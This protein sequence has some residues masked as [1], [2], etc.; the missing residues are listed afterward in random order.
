[1]ECVTGI[2]IAWFFFFLIGQSLA[3]MPDSFHD[4][5]IWQ[6]PWIDRR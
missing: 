2:V 6:V 1:V 5:T 4:G 3:N